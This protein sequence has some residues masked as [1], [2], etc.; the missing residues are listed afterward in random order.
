MIAPR[1]PEKLHY[2]EGCGEELPQP[3]R[4]RYGIQIC[5]ACGTEQPR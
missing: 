5:T 4:D 1:T 3:V 2:C